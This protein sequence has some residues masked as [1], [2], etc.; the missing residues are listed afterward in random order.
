K[1]KK[2]VDWERIEIELKGA[3]IKKENIFKENPQQG[4]FNFFYPHCPDGIY[5]VKQYE[6]ITIKDVYPGID[7]VWYSH[8]QKGYKYDF[9]VHPG[10]NYKQIEL[11]YKSKTPIKINEQGELELYTLYGNIKENTP[12]SYYQG[13][14][15]NTKFKLLAQ[16]P[17]TIHDDRGF[18]TRIGFELPELPS[19]K[20]ELLGEE[21]IIDPQLWWATFYGGNG[22]DGP[23]NMAIDGSGSIFIVGYVTSSN[24]PL[25]NAGTFFQGTLSGSSGDAFISKFSS[26]GA[27]QWSTYYGGFGIN[28]ANSLTIDS[29]G[30]IF[31]TGATSSTSFPLQNAGTFYQGVYGGGLYDAFILK[32][33]N[34]GNRLWATYYGGNGNDYGYSITTDKYG[35]VFITGR[36]SS[37]N[38][39]LQNAGTFFQ[40]AIGGSPGMDVFILKFDNGGNRL[41]ATYYG[42]N[43][44]DEG[45]CVI[46]DNSGNLFVTGNCGN[47][48]PLQNGGTFFQSTYGG[49]IADVFILKFDNNGNRLWA[50]YY[51]GNGN[52]S[53]RC[54]G[55][56]NLGNLFISGYTASN[57]FPTQNPGGAY[58]FQ[59][60]YG[61]NNDAFILKFDNVG[62]RIWATYFGGSG[63]EEEKST[64]NLVIDHCNNLYVAFRTTSSF[65]FLQNSCDVGFFDNTYNGGG[66]DILL[67]FFSNNGGLLWCTYIGGDG[68]DFRPV[69]ALDGD[70]NLYMS[71]EWTNI[72]GN[73]T[74]STYSLANPGGGAYYDFTFNGNDDGFIVKFLK[75]IINAYSNSTNPLCEGQTLN[76]NA[77]SIGSCS[78]Q[79]VGPNGFFSMQQNPSIYNVT[80]SNGGWYYVNIEEFCNVVDSIF[81]TI[82]AGP[83]VVAGSNSPLCEGQALTLTSLPNGMNNY[84]WSGPNGYI[85]TQQNPTITNSTVLHSGWYYVMVTDGNG[86]QGIDSVQVIINANPILILGSNSPLCEGDNLSLSGLPNGMSSYNWSGPNGFSSAMQNP[87]LANVTTANAGVYTLTVVDGNGCQGSGTVNVVITPPPVASIYAS[88]TSIC[89]GDTLHLIGGGSGSYSWTANGSP[90]GSSSVLIVS[91][92]VNTTYQ[93]TVS[94]GSCS[95]TAS[96][97]ITVNS[98]PVVDAMVSQAVMCEG[99]TLYLQSQ[100]NGMSSYSWVG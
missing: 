21:L 37:L 94:A 15:L 60:T 18:E 97:V 27:L 3:S 61:G 8:P 85:S 5:E 34:N 99:E 63:D 48:F 53:G 51:G 6:K 11:V 73:L 66:S 82:N 38:F 92:T 88:S 20:G 76:L 52:E 40:P 67:S 43:G 33:D 1:T 87:T 84:N 56:D 25:Q 17:I 80:L 78:Y 71:G 45:Y 29:W 93:L 90:A 26:T 47:N 74:S 75:P 13:K 19:P 72:G 62:N 95:S 86:C 30:N 16:K 7:W 77:S 81:V 41:W 65:P 58:F 83:S 49:D 35:N 79:W 50:T 98:L 100:P 64:D 46:T 70:D 36:T 22:L 42:G 32:F 14:T 69:F 89:E 23:M 55:L 9:I 96:I 44:D 57:N 59:G 24:F 91:P 68:T 39:P 4:H 2:F 54:M 31:I 12:V 28:S 10:A